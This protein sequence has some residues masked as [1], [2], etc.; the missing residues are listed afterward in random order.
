MIVMCES[1]VEYSY[2]V[3]GSEICVAC[4]AWCCVVLRGAAC[5]CLYLT[6]LLCG[7]RG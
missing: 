5:V 1:F 2:N 7:K 6:V 4:A 3:M